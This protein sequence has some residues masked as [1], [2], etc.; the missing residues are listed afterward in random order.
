[1]ISLSFMLVF[2]LARNAARNASPVDNQVHYWQ[3]NGGIIVDLLHTRATYWGIVIDSFW[4]WWWDDDDDNNDDNVC[5][6]VWCNR[7][8]RAELCKVIDDIGHAS[9]RVWLIIFHL[10]NIVWCGGIVVRASD[11]QVRV[12]APP[13]HVTTLGKLS[14]HNVPLFTNLYKL[15]PATGW[16]GNR[17]LSGISTYTGS[18]A[19]K[20]R[21]APRLS[22]IRST[23][24]SL[25]LLYV[26]EL[27]LR[28]LQTNL[29]V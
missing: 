3:N 20:G 24:T 5:V 19:W 17:R 26:D 1:M 14:T 2:H 6:V 23:T 13:L 10:D 21:C 12:P 27:F 4:I 22:S 7:Q 18:V 25:P 29:C 11:S 15:V 8:R 28:L 16:E 9:A